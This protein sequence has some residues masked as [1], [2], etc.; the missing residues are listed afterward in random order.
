MC[1]PLIFFSKGTI[2]RAEDLNKKP[3]STKERTKEWH[4]KRMKKEYIQYR[5]QDAH[6]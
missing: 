4:G 1:C 6:E 2:R 3:R 5:R